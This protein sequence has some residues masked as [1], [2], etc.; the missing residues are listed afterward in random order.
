M[1]SLDDEK[2]A[3]LMSESWQELYME[4]TD[5][6]CKNPEIEI[7]SSMIN[8]PEEKREAFYTHFNQV[9]RAFLNDKFSAI[10][11]KSRALS[12][13]YLQIEKQVIDLLG[14][15]SISN[16][17]LLQSFLC[18]PAKRLT[19]EQF[20]ML[21]S[22][23][24]GKID[25]QTF[26]A[27]SVKKI[28][29]SSHKLYLNGYLKWLELSLI[30]ILEAKS[31]L[32]VSTRPI[33]NEKDYQQIK[34]T[35]KVLAPQESKALSLDRDKDIRFTVPDFI[36]YSDTI[37]KYISIRS[38]F[39][40]SMI[41]ADN[42][43]KKREWCAI[44]PMF[45]LD[46]KYILV[47]EADNAEELSLVADSVTVCRPDL[48]IVCVDPEDSID[49]K[50]FNEDVLINNKIKSVLGTFVVSMGNMSQLKLENHIEDIHMLEVGL[51]AA[52]LKPIVEVLT[53]GGEKSNYVGQ[54]ET[55]PK[56]PS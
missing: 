4:L 52:K 16:S 51:S 26:E 10:I 12:E 14:L 41:R 29:F 37:S 23:L 31:I 25:I 38:N 50:R 44:D 55:S 35:E 2:G 53:D 43:S 13:S 40:H 22:L 46:P 21:F 27:D 5:F 15:D 45:S 30:K 39:R 32:Q 56:K 8:I 42:K 47:Y 49:I 54:M 1:S 33:S 19:K 36:I 28:R 11:N 17:P 18:E 34:I 24:K 6:I 7:T 9:R 3:V 48:V 20:D